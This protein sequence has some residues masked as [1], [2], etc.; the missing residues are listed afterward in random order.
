MFFCQ[1]NDSLSTYNFGH[2]LVT[3]S[4]TA[5]IPT[6]SLSTIHGPL[7]ESNNVQRIKY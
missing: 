3:L 2:V 5:V 4:S 1:E 6:H 7:L